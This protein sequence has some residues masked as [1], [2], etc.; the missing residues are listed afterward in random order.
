MLIGATLPAWGR[1]VNASELLAWLSR[2]RTYQ[3]LRPLWRALYTAS[4]HIALPVS[5]GRRSR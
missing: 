2:Y 1:L 4:P 5:S 3:A